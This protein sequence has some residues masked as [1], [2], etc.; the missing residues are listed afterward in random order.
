MEM[1]GLSFAF[2][3]FSSELFLKLG[4]HGHVPMDL[5]SYV[6]RY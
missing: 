2:L 3:F 4:E 6:L 1:D 5:H